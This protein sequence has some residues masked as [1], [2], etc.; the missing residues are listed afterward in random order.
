VIVPGAGHNESLGSMTWTIIEEW[1][2]SV[3]T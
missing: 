1:I 3:L 2:D